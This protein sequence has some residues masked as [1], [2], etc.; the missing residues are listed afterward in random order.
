[1]FR[2]IAV[3]VEGSPQRE[4]VGLVNHAA[5]DP[6]DPVAGSSEKNGSGAVKVTRDQL[7]LLAWEHNLDGLSWI[8]SRPPRDFSNSERMSGM[9]AKA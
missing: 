8:I 1:M 2:Q 9:T 6:V 7:M 4:E 5:P 3:H